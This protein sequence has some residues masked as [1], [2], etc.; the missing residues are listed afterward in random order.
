M[1]EK[2]TIEE[3]VTRNET[4]IENYK[5]AFKRFC[6]NDFEHLRKKVDWIFTLLL[7]TL[8]GIAADLTILLVRGK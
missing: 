2:L 4:N 8:G 7:V 5:D 3:R 6:E 1:S